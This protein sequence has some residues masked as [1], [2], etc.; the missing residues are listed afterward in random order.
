MV[1]PNEILR[2]IARFDDYT[3]LYAYLCQILE[4]EECEVMRQVRVVP[5][6]LGHDN[7]KPAI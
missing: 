6:H 7:E 5:K 1:K 2:V 4:H 3:G